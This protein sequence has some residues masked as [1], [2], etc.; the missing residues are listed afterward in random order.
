MTRKIRASARSSRPQPAA[1]PAAEK[2]RPVSAKKKTKGKGFWHSLGNAVWGMLP[3][4]M[5]FLLLDPKQPMV[6]SRR[7][8]FGPA[9]FATGG[10]EQLSE[11]GGV[12]AAGV[13]RTDKTKFYLDAK[14]VTTYA[15]ATTLSGKS[16]CLQWRTPTCYRATATSEPVCDD[17][18]NLNV[19]TDI[20]VSFKNMVKDPLSISA[21]TPLATINRPDLIQTRTFMEMRELGPDGRTG[22]QIT[23]ATRENIFQPFYENIGTANPADPAIQHLR[24]LDFTVTM[25]NE[26]QYTESTFAEDREMVEISIEIDYIADQRRLEAKG[27]DRSVDNL[28]QLRQLPEYQDYVAVDSYVPPSANFFTQVGCLVK[29]SVELFLEDT[30]TRNKKGNPVA[31]LRFLVG[32]KTERVFAP[33]FACGHNTSIL[34]VASGCYFKHHDMG[35]QYEWLIDKTLIRNSPK[36]YSD[37]LWVGY[38]DNHDMIHPQGPSSFVSTMTGYS[39]A[40]GVVKATN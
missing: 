1:Q 15:Q 29:G 11:M 22:Y 35:G 8:G 12:K 10:V 5:S 18:G 6:S 38:R 23:Y 26:S 9:T 34:H 27:G 17:R 4:V 21:T 14:L 13:K 33:A 31:A 24:F 40:L 36:F 30:K 28:F 39:T 3:E 32:D 2:S 7:L 20:R 16:F 19:I 25:P 37:D